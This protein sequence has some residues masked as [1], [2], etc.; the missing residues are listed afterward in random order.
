MILGISFFLNFF[1]PSFCFHFL[2][3][4]IFYSESSCPFALLDA[5]AP[6]KFSLLCLCILDFLM[7]DHS[8]VRL[9][10]PSVSFLLFVCLCHLLSLVGR[11]H[12]KVGPF[13]GGI[14][15]TSLF[16]FSFIP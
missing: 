16:F 4:P 1:P 3:F 11:A 6:G 5:L 14:V 12:P 9:T 15:H 7:I 8:S 2:V 13:V 10:Y